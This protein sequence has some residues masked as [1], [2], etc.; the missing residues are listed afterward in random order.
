MPERGAR[1]G[2][3]PVHP[4]LVS[5]P[6]GLWT[7]SLA[8]DLVHG[9]G[10]GSI[11]R[12]LALYTLGAGIVGAVIAAVPG[13]IDYLTIS[14]G[15]VRDIAVAHMATM[16]V[17]LGVFAVSFWLRWTGTMGALPV[18]VSAL[19]V[20]LLGI[21]AWVGAEMVYVHGQGMVADPLWKGHPREGTS[22]SR[23]RVA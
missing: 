15:R 3:H 7:F 17:V 16:L 20:A 9:L 23:R 5:L 11:W 10:G 1:F 2:G 4:A 14:D 19:G 12:D 6:I 18:A 21:G 13:F 22:P 8:A